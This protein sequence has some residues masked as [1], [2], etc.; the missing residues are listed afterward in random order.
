MCT[1]PVSNYGNRFIN[2]LQYTI[3]K[4]WIGFIYTQ[5]REYDRFM[6]HV[7]CLKFTFHN[8]IGE[9]RGENAISRFPAVRKTGSLDPFISLREAN[10]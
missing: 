6:K 4:G 8:I 9:S 7:R 3:Q 5:D 2:S 10:Y 1:I